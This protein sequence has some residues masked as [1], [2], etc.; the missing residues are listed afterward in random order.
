MYEAKELGQCHSQFFAEICKSKCS[1][2]MQHNQTVTSAC[3]T[4]VHHFH[5]CQVTRNRGA[6]I[7]VFQ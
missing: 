7:G 6:G 1:L 5:G 2:L 3:Q 4:V